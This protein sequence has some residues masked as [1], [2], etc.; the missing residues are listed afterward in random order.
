MC[1][2]LVAGTRF[3]VHLEK[4]MNGGKRGSRRFYESLIDDGYKGVVKPKIIN[5]FIDPYPKS[6]IIKIK[7]RNGGY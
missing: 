3:A 5:G 4:C 6:L 1:H 7:L 2:E